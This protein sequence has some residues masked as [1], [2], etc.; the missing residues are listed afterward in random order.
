MF[1]FCLSPSTHSDGVFSLHFIK[2]I[3][4][5]KSAIGESST[6]IFDCCVSPDEIYTLMLSY[7]YVS[8]FRGQKIISSVIADVT[9]DV[10]SRSLKYKPQG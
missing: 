1:L 3:F 5:I 10:T 7:S 6:I 9:V 2:Y 4:R 8:P